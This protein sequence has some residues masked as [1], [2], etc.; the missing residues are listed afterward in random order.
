MPDFRREWNEM[1]NDAGNERRMDWIFLLRQQQQYMFFMRSLVFSP[2]D[3][4]IN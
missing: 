4:D 2:F 1:T 3:Y